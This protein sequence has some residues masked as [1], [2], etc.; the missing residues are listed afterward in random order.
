MSKLCQDCV[1]FLEHKK[2]VVFCDYDYWEQKEK[3][4]AMIFCAEMFECIH[5]ESIQSLNKEKRAYY[6]KRDY[7]ISKSVKQFI[8]EN[9]DK[10][11]TVVLEDID[12]V[13]F[14][15]DKNGKIAVQI[16]GEEPEFMG[17]AAAGIS[18]EYE[19]DIIDIN[20]GCPAKK[21]VKNGA[22]SA[23]MKNLD[24]AY[25]VIKSTVENSNVP[26][27][28]KMRSGWSEDN[29]NAVELAKIAEEAGAAAAA[30]HGRT[31]N[32]FYKGEANWEIIKKVA[33]AVEIPVIANGDIFSA[34]DAKAAFKK[35]N[36]EGIMIGR[37]QTYGFT[38]LKNEL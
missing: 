12:I 23:L 13:K 9:K 14:D 31:R 22:G 7:E 38:Y 20:M 24:L 21:I 27:T 29:I 35:T 26:V 28:V 36:C 16:F 25:K 37:A 17:R 34:E 30:V 8:K 33:Q 19:L 3:K 15:K 4:E 32:Q 6:H 1:N 10:K 11:I 2:D 18:S 5:Y